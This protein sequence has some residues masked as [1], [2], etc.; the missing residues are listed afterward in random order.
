MGK[1]S[2]AEPEILV[3]I[4]RID[5][6]SVSFPFADC[7]AIVKGVTEI[8]LRGVALIAP[9]SIDKSPIVIPTPDENPDSLPV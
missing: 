8:W 4:F 2:V 5:N 7:T 3:E 1:T 6:Q 9:V